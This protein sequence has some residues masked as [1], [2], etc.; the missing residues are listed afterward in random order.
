[1][2]KSKAIYDKFQ[3]LDK[4][5]DGMLSH[6]ELRQVR[7]ATDT[8]ICSMADFFVT[9][10]FEEHVRGISCITGQPAMSLE[11]FADFLLAWNFR[12]RAPSV[13]CDSRDSPDPCEMVA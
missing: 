10:V 11:E 9:R 8:N 2:Q 1:L 6:N 5:R 7:L 12:G 3:E 4:D 13:K